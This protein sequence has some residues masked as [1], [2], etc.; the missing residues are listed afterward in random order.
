MENPNRPITSKEFE[1]VLASEKRSAPDGFIIEFYQT[2]EELKLICLEPS[3]T[4]KM[5]EYFE[6][7]FQDHMNATKGHYKKRKL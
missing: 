5:R 1:W 3:K 4:L 2:F 7:F 6:H